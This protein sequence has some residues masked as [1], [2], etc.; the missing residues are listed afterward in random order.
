MKRIRIER[1]IATARPIWKIRARMSS[2]SKKVRERPMRARFDQRRVGRDPCKIANEPLQE[3]RLTVLLLNL[4]IP[5]NSQ[6]KSPLASFRQERF[7]QELAMGR[8]HGG[9]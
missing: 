4:E 5:M 1:E 7:A 8:S 2:S 6:L 9:F 3:Q